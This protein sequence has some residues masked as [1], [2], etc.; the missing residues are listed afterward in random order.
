MGT[1]GSFGRGAGDVDVVILAG[2][3]GTR[4]MPWTDDHPK[5]MLPLAGR[6]L[7]EHVM[8]IYA[9]R[10]FTRFILAVGYRG[11]EIES[12]LEGLRHPWSV[13]FT[14]AGEDAGTGRRVL[15]AAELTAGTF[16]ATY[17][18]GLADVDLDA[19]L[20]RHRSAGVAAT[21]TVARMRSQYGTVDVDDSGL[22]S[23]FRE[24]PLIA[25][26]WI[27]GGFFV[28][29]AEALRSGFGGESLEDDILPALASAGQLAAHRHEGYWRSIDTFK[30]LEEV[31][32]SVGE[33]G[34]PWAALPVAGSS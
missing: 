34:A 23:A 6:P 1:A 18:D 11:E 7:V 4:A 27:N 32:R 14:R 9:D 22:V 13:R 24:K 25:D 26:V 21:V 15:A 29:E 33:G 19:L 10:G 12:Y 28:F 16:H 17:A 20:E 3:R 8:R 5:A 31:D 30:D 2:G